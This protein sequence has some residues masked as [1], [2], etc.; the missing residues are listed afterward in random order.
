MA[1]LPELLATPVAPTQFAALAAIGERAQQD[2]E[3]ALRAVTTFDG[4]VLLMR[5]QSRVPGFFTWLYGQAQ[6]PQNPLKGV[7]DVIA[8]KFLKPALYALGEKDSDRFTDLMNSLPVFTAK[9]PLTQSPSTVEV[10][11]VISATKRETCF[12]KIFE[13]WVAVWPVHALILPN[14]FANWLSG[15]LFGATTSSDELAEFRKKAVNAV[16][17]QLLDG[18]AEPLEKLLSHYEGYDK[19]AVATQLVFPA[20]WRWPEVV[21]EVDKREQVW[22]KLYT[23]WLRVRARSTGWVDLPFL[24]QWSIANGQDAPPG[25]GPPETKPDRGRRGRI[26]A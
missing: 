2:F 19:F 24:T 17:G 1:I 6:D 3:K 14:Q 10:F 12:L 16:Y 5:T 7:F 9:D 22:K 20:F 4:F 23:L 26:W 21:N 18:N 13:K 15:S 25:A 8:D 11:D